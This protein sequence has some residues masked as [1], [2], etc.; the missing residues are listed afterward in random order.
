MAVK[1]GTAGVL[2]RYAVPVPELQIPINNSPDRQQWADAYT[3]VGHSPD[4]VAQLTKG[5]SLL[6]SK[7]IF[8]HH[9]QTRASN[10]VT[11]RVATLPE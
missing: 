7:A 11:Q 3:V 8:E 2:Q 1:A 6:S 4:P 5:F 10:Y 9:V